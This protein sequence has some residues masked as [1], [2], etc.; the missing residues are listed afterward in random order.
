MFL[1]GTLLPSLLLLCF[2]GYTQ[3]Y[4]PFGLV[5]SKFDEQN[6]VLSPDGRTLYFTRANHP[7]NV[8]GELDPGDIWFSNKLPDDKWSTPTNLTSLNH[9]GWNGILGFV[10]GDDLMYLYGQYTVNGGNTAAKG[11]SRSLSTTAGWSTPENFNIPYFRSSSETY[12]GFISEDA[13][14]A[15]FSL[16]TYGT[17]GGEDLYVT[18]NKG[19]GQWS[20]LKNLGNIV[21]TKFQE[22]SPFLSKDT[23]KLYFSSN[24]RE[25]GTDIYVSERLDDTWTNWTEPLPLI[26]FNTDGKEMGLR[27]YG[28][29]N[30]YVSTKDSDGYGDLKMFIDPEALPDTTNNIPLDTLIAP[31]DPIP[32]MVEAEPKFDDRFITLYGNTFSSSTNEP[33]EAK[34]TLK[35]QEEK[36]VSNVISKMGSYA[37]K[38]ESIG[39]YRIR[40]DAP[41]YVSHQE[42]LELKSDQIKSLEKSFTLQPIEVGTRVNLKDVLFK[43]SLAEFLPD[44]YAELNLVVDFMRDNPNVEI[45][46]E[47]HTDNRGVAKYNLRLSKDRVEAVKDYL[48][49]KGISKKRISGKG[50]GG[51]QPLVDNNDPELRILNRRVEFIIVKN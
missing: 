19:N 3:P 49:K 9:K 5:N 39:I 41:G 4:D 7:E 40:V 8:G 22:F 21:N 51:S 2:F 43:Q 16:E 45:R 50:Y 23:R 36:E 38:I 35:N 34:I 11:L 25:K 17:R 30:I 13:S 32:T 12:G 15:I 37:L 18:F 20:E 33:I 6:P 31:V 24:G 48:V 28:A 44:S 14:I 1:K 27:I 42:I 46:L 47:G 29:K 10:G 26:L